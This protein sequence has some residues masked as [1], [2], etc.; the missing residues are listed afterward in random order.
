[1][2]KSENEG[3]WGGKGECIQL[4]ILACA[5]VLMYTQGIEY[6]QGVFLMYTQGIERDYLAE[7]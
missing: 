6:A 2:M 4:E 5:E 1:M 7:N 3:M